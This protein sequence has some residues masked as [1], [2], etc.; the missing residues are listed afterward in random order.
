MA[1][2]FEGQTSTAESFYESCIRIFTALFKRLE[3][4]FTRRIQACNSESHGRLPREDYVKMVC[5]WNQEFTMDM[6]VGNQKRKEFFDSVKALYNELET[7][8]LSSVLSLT[9]AYKALRELLGR[10]ASDGDSPML[11]IALD[12]VSKLTE[13]RGGGPN[14][15]LPSHIL[16]QVIKLYSDSDNVK[17]AIW[18]LFSSTNVRVT[19]F[20]APAPICKLKLTLS[21]H[22]PD[23]VQQILLNES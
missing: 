11:V 9:N 14:R 19:H 4:E 7:S 23:Q 16:G 20:T 13:W 17:P 12:E 10:F 1:A 5:G 6:S 3:T 2:L 21:G 8:Q 18:V 15:W 22:Q